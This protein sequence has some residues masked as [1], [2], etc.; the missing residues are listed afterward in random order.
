MLRSTA[1]PQSEAPAPRLLAHEEATKKSLVAAV[2]ERY[3]SGMGPFCLHL[4]CHGFY[5][6]SLRWESALMLA[7]G[8]TLSAGDIVDLPLHK[9]HLAVLSAC[10]TGLVDTASAEAV[11][12]TSALLVAGVAP[13]SVAR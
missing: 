9:C 10:Q 12:L 11:G 7:G 5:V 3:S 2:H 6:P 8:S 1:D 13:D 4:S